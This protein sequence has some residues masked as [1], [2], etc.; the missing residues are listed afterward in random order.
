M[1]MM[2]NLLLTWT[3]ASWLRTARV[4]GAHLAH[5]RLGEPLFNGDLVQRLRQGAFHHSTDLEGGV[6]LLQKG[7][8]RSPQKA[9]GRARAMRTNGE[10]TEGM[11]EA[12]KTKECWPQQGCHKK[13]CS[14]CILLAQAHLQHKRVG[15][16]KAAAVAEDVLR[17]L[18]RL[19][20]RGK[21]LLHRDAPIRQPCQHLTGG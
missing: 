2:S 17:A 21:L 7:R 10:C 19:A 3:S 14:A 20:Q 16:L 4:C 18:L 6:S 11:T 15:A 5:I 13:M 9:L 8:D 1:S 12:V